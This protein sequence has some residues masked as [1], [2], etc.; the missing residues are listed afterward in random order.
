MQFASS[1]CILG[2]DL[3]EET[4][5]AMRNAGIEA[6]EMVYHPRF[7]HP[8]MR[9]QLGEWLKAA[10]L[11]VHSLHARFGYVSI[12]TPDDA[13]RIGSILEILRELEFMIELGGNC[14][15]VHS[16]GL[17][18]DDA[19]RPE[20]FRLCRESLKII[21]EACAARGVRLALEFLPRSCLGNNSRELLDLIEGIDH[22]AVGVCLDTNHANL[23]HD[24]VETIAT[25]AD[26]I[27]AVHVSDNDGV[28]E[29]HWFPYQGVIDWRAFAEAIRKSGFD[30]PCMY[31]V[32]CDPKAGIEGRLEFLRRTHA[33]MWDGAP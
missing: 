23:G 15:V 3:S 13:M 22:G 17:I 16:G 27:I 28:V 33:R 11:R 8:Q 9:K 6:V 20:L 12:S 14:L 10:E 32:V 7:A 2:Q 1:T 29:R 25:L 5:R 4:F 31:E 26:K 30:G 21:A 18:L 24:L 19:K